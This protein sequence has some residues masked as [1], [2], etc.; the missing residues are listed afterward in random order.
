M[1]FH[2]NDALTVSLLQESGHKSPHYSNH[3][4]PWCTRWLVKPPHDVGGLPFLWFNCKSPLLR[5][6][7][8]TQALCTA[9]RTLCGGR[10]RGGG[11]C[12]L[13]RVQWCTH[14]STSFTLKVE[15]FIISSSSSYFQHIEIH[16]SPQITPET[17][18]GNQI[19][20]APNK[21]ELPWQ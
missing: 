15:H 20:R 6:S 11:I 12:R 9:L 19:H 10:G 18:T 7:R 2:I 21:S 5:P 14:T 17:T 3:K 1:C 13:T 8:V 16:K 4:T